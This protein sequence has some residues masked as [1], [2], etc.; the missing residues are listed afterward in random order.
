MSVLLAAPRMVMLSSE[1]MRSNS[2][3]VLS[4]SVGFAI[5]HKV[6]SQKYFFA[7]LI[8]GEV[9]G[10]P[11]LATEGKHHQRVKKVESSVIDWNWFFLRGL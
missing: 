6:F 4:L 5:T 10:P 7:S 8:R 2:R 1:C 9:F 3:I 11:P